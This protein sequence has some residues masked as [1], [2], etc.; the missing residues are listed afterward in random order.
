MSR[1]RI[2][3]LNGRAVEKKIQEPVPRTDVLTN[4]ACPKAFMPVRIMTVKSKLIHKSACL[5]V[6]INSVHDFQFYLLHSFIKKKM[7]F[8]LRFKDTHSLHTYTA[9][10]HSTHTHTL[11]PSLSIYSRASLIRTLWF[12]A[13]SSG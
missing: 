4:F 12:P 7:F 2:F 3:H 1:S 10:H 8:T 9:I 6:L 5:L 13:K 11:S